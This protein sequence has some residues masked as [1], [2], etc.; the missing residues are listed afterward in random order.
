MFIHNGAC[1]MAAVVADI[2][3]PIYEEDPGVV[4]CVQG[5]YPPGCLVWLLLV[6][7]WASGEGAVFPR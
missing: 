7:C 4:V 2:C 5:C 1:G 3:R 6:A